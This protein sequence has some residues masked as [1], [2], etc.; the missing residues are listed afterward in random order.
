LIQAPEPGA[1][2]RMKRLVGK[3]IFV[4]NRADRRLHSSV[5]PTTGPARQNGKAQWLNSGCGGQVAFD[6][7]C[8][9]PPRRKFRQQALSVRF[10]DSCQ[11]KRSVTPAVGGGGGG[12][13]GGGGRGPPPPTCRDPAT[14][15]QAA[16]PHS[17]SRQLGCALLP[18]CPCGAARTRSASLEQTGPA[19]VELPARLSL[20]Q[21]A[22]GNGCCRSPT[23]GRTSRPSAAR[24]PGAVGCRP[25]WRAAANHALKDRPERRRHHLRRPTLSSPPVTQPPWLHRPFD[26]LPPG[27]ASL[28]GR[29]GARSDMSGCCALSGR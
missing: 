16:R 7:A 12:G 6:G 28:E 9:A 11:L 5:T 27:G 10:G 13:E 20:D 21:M 8:P 4:V 14:R 2:R 29:S 25:R 17:S 26:R 19:V 22:R 23:E 1:E 18:P 15:P 24:T 3:V